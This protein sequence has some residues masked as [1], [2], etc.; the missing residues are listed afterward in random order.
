MFIFYSLFAIMLSH[1]IFKYTVK[2][3]AI[4]L[5]NLYATL[6]ANINEKKR[7]ENLKNIELE[8]C[9]NIIDTIKEVYFILP[10]KD[11]EITQIFKEEFKKVTKGDPLGKLNINMID[12]VN[13]IL[14]EKLD[15][16][17]INDIKLFIEYTFLGKS[18]KAIL[19]DWVIFPFYV[20]PEKGTK[21]IPKRKVLSVLI[22]NNSDPSKNT[23]ITDII[24]QYAGPMHTF[25]EEFCGIFTPKNL[26]YDDDFN[27]EEEYEYIEEDDEELEIDQKI[28]IIDS[29]AK[30]YTTSLYSDSF[31]WCI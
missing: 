20:P 1:T 5:F 27:V 18:Y 4:F 24:K 29:K 19:E 8:R 28:N 9:K 7:I 30:T 3:P 31:E 14:D 17:N 26:L 15:K 22:G 6:K 10:D 11:I 13:N 12:F 21:L 16:E 23:D 2:N 25:H